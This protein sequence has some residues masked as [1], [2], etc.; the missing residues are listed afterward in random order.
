MIEMTYCSSF[1]TIQLFYRIFKEM[2]EMIYY[3]S[4]KTIQLFYRNFKNDDIEYCIVSSKRPD[5]SLRSQA[6]SEATS[7]KDFHTTGIYIFLYYYLF[8]KKWKKWQKWQ[9]WQK[10][11]IA[12]LSKLYYFFTDFQKWWY[13][14]THSMLPPSD[15]IL[16]INI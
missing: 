12:I 7:H 9:K 1:K 13:N 2:I 6:R 15:S 11:H 16:G 5:G 4:M 3:N 8:L 10:W 14:S